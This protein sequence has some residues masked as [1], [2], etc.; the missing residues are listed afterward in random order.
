MDYAPRVNDI[1][2]EG[3]AAWRIHEE[4]MAA[5]ARGE[6]ILPLS[7][8]DPDFATPAPVVERARAAMEAGDTHYTDGIG[9]ESLRTAIARHFSG[10]LGRRLSPANV[11][12]TAGAQNALYFASQLLLGPGDEAIMLCPAYITYEA[13]IRSS[14]A[15]PVMVDMTGASGFRPD[16]AA[17]AAAITPRTRALFLTTPNNPTGV[18]LD[19][20]EL[21][22][23]AEIVRRHDLWVVSDEVYAALIFEGAHHSI[24]ALPGMAE[25]TLTISSLSKSHAMTGWRCGWMIGPEALI[26]HAANLSLCMLYGLPGFVQQA[27]E[28]ALERADEITARH[29]DLFRARRDHMIRGLGTIPGIHVLEPQAGMFAMADVRGTGLTS[30]QFA[31]RLLR[32]QGVSVLD[33][34]AFG[35]SAAGF[36]RISFTLAEARIDDAC[37]RIAALYQDIA[38]TTDEEA[39][40]G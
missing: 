31:W 18:A 13:T 15:T 11:C 14:G 33:G 24:A 1:A 26:G 4:A 30:E 6:R 34:A 21:A 17:I 16:P 7:I 3:A 40:H 39:S 20:E 5:L 35:R 9:T 37:R 29:R 25:R 10:P 32:E 8:G 22:A 2:G 27:A 36:V 38:N 19:R 23:I 28:T 12:V